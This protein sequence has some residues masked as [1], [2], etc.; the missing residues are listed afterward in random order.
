MLWSVDETQ[1]SDWRHGDVHTVC[2]ET[3][4]CVA[5]AACDMNVELTCT[6]SGLVATDGSFYTSILGRLLSWVIDYV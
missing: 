1:E 4:W 6:I 2:M 3:G 5:V